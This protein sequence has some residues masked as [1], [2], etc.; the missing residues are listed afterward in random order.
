LLDE[1]L[2]EY[3]DTGD[4]EYIDEFMGMLWES[5]Y[6]FKKYKKSYTFEVDKERLHNR[7]DLIELFE[8]HNEIEFKFCKSFYKKRLEYIDYIRIHVNN[9]YGF[10]VDKELYLPKEYYHLLLSPK[11][12]YYNTVESL[13]NGEVVNYEEVKSKIETS[14][15][16]AENLK[17]ETLKKKLDIK[18]KDYKKLIHN[19]IE[20]IF[21]NYKPPHEYEQEHGW[22][23]AVYVDGWSENNYV[24][25]Y[26]CKSLTGYLRNYVKSQQPKE[27]KKKFC[28]N[29]NLEIFS[30]GNRKKYCESCAKKIKR[31]QDR[32]ADK[33]YK[34]KV[35]SEKIEPYLSRRISE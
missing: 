28:V 15:N 16:E 27:N 11:R 21:N 32:I 20:R 10:L 14:I 35:K 24:V 1:I 31:K 9:M 2:E 33:K 23:M 34:E 6:K 3:K 30:K 25:K 4:K 8:K 18:W 17:K 7:E 19:Y 26:F 13:S 29:C 5:K 22:Q 12:E